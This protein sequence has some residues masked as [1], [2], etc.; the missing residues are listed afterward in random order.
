MGII[1][2]DYSIVNTKGDHIHYV[3]PFV[4]IQNHLINVIIN[5]QWQILQRLNLRRHL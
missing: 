2:S 4:I 3:L 5:Y 1:K